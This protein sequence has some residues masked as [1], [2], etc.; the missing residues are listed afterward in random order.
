VVFLALC[1]VTGLHG[2]E[3]S[4]ASRE[5]LVLLDGTTIIG[6]ITAI[7]SDGRIALGNTQKR[8][9]LDGLRRIERMANSSNG[10]VD[11]SQGRRIGIELLDGGRL[12]AHG[13]RIKEERCHVQWRY[14]TFSLPLD[15]VRAVRLRPEQRNPDFEKAL[16]AGEESDRLFA[17]TDNKPV[18]VK[19]FIEELDDENIAFERNGQRETIPRPKLFGIVVALVGSTSEHTG[20][21]LLDLA[22]GSSVWGRIESLETV[23]PNQSARLTFSLRNDA[24]VTIPWDSVAS[25]SVQ[26]SRLVYLSD[27]TPIQIVEEPI[28]AFPRPWQRDRS[29]GRRP[30]TLDGRTFVK[31]IGVQA[32]SQLTLNAGGEFELMTATIGIDAEAAGRGDCEF[33]VLA[34][35]RELFRK[36]MRGIDPPSDLRVDIQ[37]VTKVT[38]L[39]EPGEDLDIGDHADW[40]DACFIR[41]PKAAQKTNP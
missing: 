15:V 23:A 3:N 13:L 26:S 19:G 33:I 18:M 41:S 9:E 20:Q 37:G 17:L 35:G 1:P 34:D 22:D 31:G 30:L 6:T 16:G 25:V 14:G 12:V 24:D 27:L 39:V 4:Q 7:S 21:C 36:R 40:C 11:D 8:F 5:R 2:Q 28:V 29:V 10:S 38:L 32:R